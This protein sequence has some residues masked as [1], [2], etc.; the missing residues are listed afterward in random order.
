MPEKI[1]I[2]SKNKKLTSKFIFNNIHTEE[3]E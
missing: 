3:Y 2:V 1:D